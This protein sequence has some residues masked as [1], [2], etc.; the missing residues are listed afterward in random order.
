MCSILY[1]ILFFNLLLASNT[2]GNPLF[3]AMLFSKT[4]LAK[5]FFFYQRLLHFRV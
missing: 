4:K 5:S 2:R 3:G 1:N